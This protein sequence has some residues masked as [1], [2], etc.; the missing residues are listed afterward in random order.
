M[1]TYSFDLKV[2]NPKKLKVSYLENGEIFR[3]RILKTKLK[4]DGYLYL[5]N[6][7]VGFLLVP[8]IAGA[9]DIKRTR[10]TKSENGNIVFDVVNHRSGAFLIVVFLDGRTWKY[11]QEYQQIE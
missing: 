11:R 2:L 1:K 4:K 8:Y 5:K 10:L 6:K 3:E 9:I 7:N